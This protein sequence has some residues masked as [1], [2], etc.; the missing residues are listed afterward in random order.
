MDFIELKGLE[1]YGYH[2][3]FENERKYGQKFIIDVIMYLDLKNISIDDDL[4]K[5]VDY[6]EVYEKI[7]YLFDDKKFKLI[8]SLAEYIAE[9]LI[10]SYSLVKKVSVTIK[11]PNPPIS[12]KYDYFAVGIN[13]ERNSK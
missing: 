7:K 11:K 13:C 3:V 1:F 4:N 6:S 12:G 10:E 2:G 8:E 9:S 5:T